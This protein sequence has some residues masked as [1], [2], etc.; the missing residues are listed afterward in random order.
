MIG[1]DDAAIFGICYSPHQPDMCVIIIIIIILL[2]LLSSIIIRYYEDFQASSG[3]SAMG[4]C[5]FS[6]GCDN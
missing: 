2:L 5:Y 3:W 4:I 1:W 6:M